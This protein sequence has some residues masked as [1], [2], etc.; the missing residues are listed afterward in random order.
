MILNGIIILLTTIM[1]IVLTGAGAFLTIENLIE[2]NGLLF[3]GVM[4]MAMGI[5]MLLVVLLA[6]TIGKTLLAYNKMYDEMLKIQLNFQKELN[7]ILNSNRAANFGSIFGANPNSITIKNLDTGETT[8]APLSGDVKD[9]MSN[10]NN[11]FSGMGIGANKKGKKP[12]GEMNLDELQ[13]ELQ[14][15]IKKDNFERASIIKELIEEKENPSG[16][17]KVNE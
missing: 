14:K 15:A 8:N 5:L 12:L 6:S 7:L 16:D 11:M 10:L 3:E 4:G 13:E 1:G 2:P 17:G 9:L